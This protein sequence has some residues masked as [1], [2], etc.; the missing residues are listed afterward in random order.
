MPPELSF[1]DLDLS[2][3]RGG[4]IFGL[5][6]N[7]GIAKGGFAGIIARILF[8]FAMTWL[9]IV[10]LLIVQDW[11]DHL[12]LL[13]PFFTN[14]TE[15]VRFL[16]VVPLLVFA[17]LHIQPWL[18]HVVQ[19]FIRSGI[20]DDKQTPKFIE[21]VKR[22]QNMR[23]S[24]WIELALLIFSFGT[25]ASGIYLTPQP[26][27]IPWLFVAGKFSLAGM[28]YRF[29]ALPICRFLWLRW[30]L[31][32]VIWWSLLTRIATLKLHLVPTHPDCRG[33]L[34]FLAAGHNNFSILWFAFS[35]QFSSM[36]GQQILYHGAT[37]NA[38]KGT[39]VLF[40]ALMVL[41][42][43]LPLLVFTP[44]LVECRRKGLYEYGILAKQYVDDFHSSVV[45]GIKPEQRKS[46]GVAEPGS[47]SKVPD[48]F[49]VVGNMSAVA[50]GKSTL[51]A[52]FVAAALDLNPKSYT[53]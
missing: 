16:I 49:K 28:W 47:M 3:L 45:D 8:F 43:I 22:S 42:S 2:I 6:V 33:G 11:S 30:F 48:N 5:L 10:V 50:F 14:F 20:I 9:P 25:A 40:I 41:F 24:L 12:D 46:Q 53:A 15:S 32:I 37:L 7:S 13:R 23:D 31:R 26:D 27:N 17:E 34:G 36:L 51:V 29:V 38:L 35:V 4:P 18:N 44:N 19:Y 21:F 1:E 52:F 39:I